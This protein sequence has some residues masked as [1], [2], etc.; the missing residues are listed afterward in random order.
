MCSE[1]VSTCRPSGS[2]R[3]HICS[4]VEPPSMITDSP[5]LHSV[6]AARPMISFCLRFLPIFSWKGDASQARPRSVLAPDQPRPAA[7]P[8]DLSVLLQPVQVAAQR[9]R[10]SL[11]APVELLEADEAALAQKLQYQLFAFGSVHE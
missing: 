5:G 3:W 6:A 4:V 10:R 2:S 1:L 8:G 11:D 9:R 7:Q